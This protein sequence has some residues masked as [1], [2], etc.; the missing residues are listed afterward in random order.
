MAGIGQNFVTKRLK[1]AQLKK[2]KYNELEQHMM[3]HGLKM[4]SKR[5]KL[6]NNLSLILEDH[7]Q[8]FKYA[9]QRALITHESKARVVKMMRKMDAFP[10]SEL[11][12]RSSLT[13]QTKKAF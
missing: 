3:D 10:A 13:T 11:G 2:R 7:P 1:E 9:K 8:L 4:P 12:N 6:D 5:K